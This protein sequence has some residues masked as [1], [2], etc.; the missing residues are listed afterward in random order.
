MIISTIFAAEVQSTCMETAHAIG[1]EAHAVSA[2]LQ[3]LEQGFQDRLTVV[4]KSNVE[5]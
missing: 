1:G 4:N 3:S 2:K 5:V